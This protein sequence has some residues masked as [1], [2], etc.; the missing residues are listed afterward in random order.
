[1]VWLRTRDAGTRELSS[2]T[3]RGNSVYAAAQ[4]QGLAVGAGVSRRDKL[5]ALGFADERQGPLAT[6]FQQG[7]S[8]QLGASAMADPNGVST[9]LQNGS[10]RGRAPLPRFPPPEAGSG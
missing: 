7:Q 10:T 8:D 9:T 2:Q 5:G 1:M 3:R 6:P 4:G